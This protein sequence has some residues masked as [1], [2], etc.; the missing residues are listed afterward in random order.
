MRALVLLA[1][2]LAALPAHA[3][4]VSTF[5]GGIYT[6]LG[7][8][9]VGTMT[10][11]SVI[12]A[13]LTV[14]SVASTMHATSQQKRRARQ[15]AAHKLQQDIANLADRR[16]TLLQSDS[17]HAVVY[18][19]PARIG[20]AIVG[21]V[22]TGAGAQ[23]THIVMVFAAHPCEAIEEL[24]IDDDPVQVGPDGWTT[25][26]TFF[27][28]P[29]GFMDYDHGP[30]V[31]VSVHL[32]PG[33]VDVADQ[34]LIDQCNS[35]IGGAPGMWTA[36][37][38]LSGFTYAVVSVNKIMDRFQGGPP[39]V[40][41]KVR[42]KASILDVRTGERGYS[43]NPALCLADFI[44]S[45]QGYGATWDQIDTAALIAAANACDQEVYGG[46]ADDGSEGSAVNF[47]GS[48]ALYVCD[49]M[50][51]SDQDRDSTRQQLEE[52]MAG[53]SMQ[54]G[55]VWRIQ[56]GAWS[57]PVLV[58][59]D[60]DMLQPSVVVQTGNPGERVYNTARGT[61]VNA[62][63][64]GVS[65]DFAQYQNETFLAL[66]PHAK[67][68]D[69]ALPFTGAHVRCHQLARVAVER[70]RG[71]LVLQIF[72]KMLAWHLQPGDRVLLS[73]AFLGFEDKAFIV[74]DWRYSRTAPLTLEVQEDVPAYYDTADEVLADAAPNSN[75][76]NPYAPP[77]PPQNLRVESGPEQIVQQV[78]GAMV[79]ARVSWAPST[80]SYVIHGGRVRVQ[81]RAGA[82]DPGQVD[83]ADAS[84][85]N[86]VE[87]PGDAVETFLLGLDVGSVYSV[88]AR[89]ETTFTASAWVYAGHTLEGNT[90]NPAEV[91]GLAL[92][93]AEDG[94][95]ARW[96]A[97]AGLDQLEWDGTQVRRGDTWPAAA[98][99]VRFDGRALTASLGWFPAGAQSVWA[100][101]RSMTGRWSSPI[102]A[103]IAIL[104][105][106]AVVPQFELTM[107]FVQLRWADCRTTQPVSRYV[108]RKGDAWDTAEPVGQAVGT[109][110]S[111]QGQVGA[112][113]YWVVAVDVAGNVGTPGAVDVTVDQLIESAL[114]VLDKQLGDAF[115]LL[116]Q[117]LTDTN[118][119][120]A[121]AVA[122]EAQ[123]RAQAIIAAAQ[124]S[125]GDLA[126]EAQARA[127]AITAAV[128]AEAQRNSQAL[129]VEAQQRVQALQ[130]EAQARGQAIA[131]EAA[132]RAGDVGAAALAEAQARAS[133][134]AL[135]AQNRAAA[136]GAE[137]VARNA[138]IQQSATALQ[139][140]I[141][142]VHAQ[143]G[144]IL[145][146]SD[147]DPARAY[148][149]GEMAKA[150]GKLYRST[151]P[152]QGH[153]PPD[154]AYWQL[155]G[156]Y[157]SIG[158][159][160]A[161]L[162]AQTEEHAAR[163]AAVEGGY[164][165]QASQ[166]QAVQVQ[167][168]SVEQSSV[169]NA[170]AIAGLTARA[171]DI[172]GRQ[173][174]QAA[175]LVGLQALTRTDLGSLVRD[176]R[177]ERPG[178]WYLVNRVAAGA[179]GVPA[180]A[181]SAFVGHQVGRD[182]SEI[183]QE[184]RVKKGDVYWLSCEAASSV[185]TLR[186]TLGVHFWS[187]VTG[188]HI[189]WG[190]DSTMGTGG[191]WVQLRG[192][193]GPPPWAT[194][195]AVWI[196]ID[197]GGDLSGQGWYIT[198]ID[199]RNIASQSVTKAAIAVQATANQQLAT[200]VEQQ[201]GQLAAQSAAQ[202]DLAGKL[203]TAQG[204]IAAQGTAQQQLATRLTQT[205][206]G[207]QVTGEQV[208]GLT[209]QIAGKADA[210]A[211]QTVSQQLQQEGERITAQAGEL[212][213]VKARVGGVEDVNAGQAQSLASQGARI[214]QNEQ[215]LVAQGQR[216]DQQQ[217]AIG[218]KA[219]A[220]ALDATTARVA[221]VESGLSSTTA[222][223]Q[224]IEARQARV[225]NYRLMSVGNVA[226]HP[227]AAAGLYDES[228]SRFVD[229]GRSWNTFGLDG[230]G[231]VYGWMTWDLHIGAAD[232]LAEVLAANSYRT[233]TGFVTCDEPS[234][235]MS[236]ALRAQLL[237]YGATAAVI[238][239]LPYRGAYILLG[240][241]GAGQGGGI[242]IV[243]PYGGE[244]RAWVTYD[245]QVIN[246][247][248]AGLAGAPGA[249]LSAAA[250]AAA[251]SATAA[252]VNQHGQDIAVQASDLAGVKARLGGVEDV[253]AGQAQS[254][255]SQGARI[256]Q[257]EQGL[258]AQGQRLDQQQAAL[259]T[260][261]SASA[262]DAT[263]VSVQQLGDRISTEAARTSVLTARMDGL[264][265]G[266][267]NLLA[268]TRDW[269]GVIG[270]GAV[271]LD[272][273]HQGLRVLRSD[274]PWSYLAFPWSLEAGQTYTLS[275]WARSTAAQPVD[276]GVY[277]FTGQGEQ[278]WRLTGEWKRYSWTFSR[279]QAVDLHVRIESAEASP[280][281]PMWVAGLK[282]ERGNVATDWMPSAADLAQADARLVAES[283]ARADADS[284][285]S[286]QLVALQGQVAGKA[287]AG[288]VQQLAQMVQ[289]QGDSIAASTSDFSQLR[290]ELGGGGNLVR[291]PEFAQGVK[292]WTAQRVD[293][294]WGIWTAG[295][296]VPTGMRALV[297]NGDFDWSFVDS[298]PIPVSAGS[299]V[300]A[301]AWVAQ[302]R[303]IAARVELVY[304]DVARV[305]LAAYSSVS[306]IAEGGTDL[307][308]WQRLTAIEAA[309]AGTRYAV[310]R[311]VAQGR[312]GNT[313]HAWYVR[314]MVFL[315]SAG[316]T[317]APPWSGSSQGV[318]ESLAAQSLAQSDLQAQV[319][320]NADGIAATGARVDSLV[321]QIAG[322][323]DASA[324]STLGQ[325]V[326]QQG[327]TQLAQADEL[328]AMRA[329]LSGAE[330]VNDGQAQT[331]AGH[332][333]RIEQN[334]QGLV[335]QGQRLD[336][337]QAAIGTKAAASALDA[338][339]ARV[340]EVESGLSSAVTRTQQLEA[341]QA[342]V[343]NFRVVSVGTNS[344]PPSATGLY[345]EDGAQVSGGLRS[346]M[347]ASFNAL[348]D[349]EGTS[350]WD[351]FA[352]AAPQMVA[353]MAT[354]PVGRVWIFWTHDEPAGGLTEE[355]KQALV[356][357]GATRRALDAIP[358]RGA[359]VLLGQQGIGEGGGLEVLSAYGNAAGA[360]AQLQ[361]QLVNGLPVGLAGKQGAALAAAALAAA[362]S[363]TAATVNQ[364]GQ[365]IAA[366]ASQIA[367][368]QAALG[369]KASSAALD[370]TNVSVQQ[371]G[372]RV[373]T[374]AAR[375]TQLTS[376]MDG[377]AVGSANL[378]TGTRDWS[379]TSMRGG[380]TV[381]DGEWQ[382][383]KVLRCEGLW[384]Y[385]AFP[386]DFVQGE[387]YTLSFWGRSDDSA[388]VGVFW[389]NG[390]ASMSWQ[391]A[392]GWKRY[393]W[394]FSLAQS[395]G[396]HVRV[397]PWTA[398][399]VWI[400]GMKL[401]RGN[402][403]TDWM[404]SAA[405]LGQV[406]A[407]LLTESSTRA[408]ADE[409]Q[410]A[411]LQQLTARMTGSEQQ[412]AGQADALGG[413]TVRMSQAEG[414]ISSTAA[415]VVQ[416]GSS[417]NR[418]QTEDQASWVPDPR[419]TDPAVWGGW[420]QHKSTAGV[421]AGA[422]ADHVLLCPIR[423]IMVGKEA[424]VKEG[425]L[426][427]AAA[428]FARSVPL[429][430]NVGIGFRIRDRDGNIIAFHRVRSEDGRV[431]SWYL[432]DG[433]MWVPP[434]AAYA[435]MW[436]Q[437]D[438]FGDMTANSSYICLP[439][440]RNGVASK[441]TRGLADA[442][443][444]AV[445]SLTSEV[446]QIGSSVDAL[447]AQSV[448]LGTSLAGVQAENNTQAEAIAQVQARS[449]ANEQ[450][451]ASQSG[452]MDGFAASLGTFKRYTLHAWGNDTG[453]PR[454]L[455]LSTGAQ[456]G[457]GGRSYNALIFNGAGEIAQGPIFDVY[458]SPAEAARMRDWV[459]GLTV[460]TEVVVYT[461]DE[462]SNGRT[463]DLYQALLMLGG[464]RKAIDQIRVHGAYML[465]GRRGMAEGDAWEEVYTGPTYQGVSRISRVLEIANGY[466]VG[467]GGNSGAAFS[468]AANA[469]ATQSLSTTVQ[470]QGGQI[471]AGAA[472]QLQ[473]EARTD[474]LESSRATLTQQL[475]VTTGTA[476]KALARYTFR[477]DVDGHVSGML[478]DN[479]GET[480]RMAFL[481]DVFSI[482]APGYAD[483][484][485]FT[486][487]T[488]GGAGA[489]G[490]R[491]DMYLDGSITARSISVTQLSAITGNLG[492][493]YTGRLDVM[494]GLT[495]EGGENWGYARSYGKWYGDGQWGWLFARRGSDGHVMAEINGPNMG[496]QMHGPSGW[497]R[498]WGPGFNLDTGGLTINQVD[499]IDTLSVRGGAIN[500]SLAAVGADYVQ[501][502]FSV[503]A[504]QSWRVACHATNQHAGP[505][506]SLL[507]THSGNYAMAADSGSQNLLRMWDLGPG[508]YGVQIS[509]AD[510]WR[511]GYANGGSDWGPPPY[512]PNGQVVNLVLHICKK[513]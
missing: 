387:T 100:A 36:D 38:K 62:A 185:A 44:T 71:G 438:G 227:V 396:H 363:A 121:Q 301:A 269:T 435:Q 306:T 443:A 219:A 411:Q 110:F 332:G 397:E 392:P 202:T 311:L 217:A 6:W 444:A 485:V 446:A 54:S 249:V 302:H 169:A 268:G 138:A 404:P 296:W 327:A 499:V 19:S 497:M 17:P 141:D 57:T 275:F 474:G 281:H 278:I 149:V 114:E 322:K 498:L 96:G 383:L 386:F 235:G 400:A 422:P 255:A 371:L 118:R 50:F 477:M 450:G 132:A 258:V 224:Q 139:A 63:Q 228:G 218:T 107:Q 160:V 335:A 253:N 125:A 471:A 479:N 47:G 489:L 161:A 402:I 431:G 16:L 82:T 72:P 390:T 405:D 156:N 374:E 352:G 75:L 469:A 248:P 197:G 204:D 346:W 312:P 504:G 313:P 398:S 273:E 293:G 328:S 442:N 168:H 295:D 28:Q 128:A 58:L 445:G 410:A 284:A 220:S 225:R 155:V 347:A 30:M 451:L 512:S 97:P 15:E 122:A 215:G 351:V 267:A 432:L 279:A 482:A 61:Y 457:S 34:W 420:R 171:T 178:A 214:E 130:A 166:L 291:D 90:G 391:L 208:A 188:Q 488:V 148:A 260:K 344:A 222:R 176:G 314:P 472:A 381:I 11:G 83:G 211:L 167:L 223:T 305:Q 234:G 236:L 254:L 142:S 135:E 210:S 157:D 370:A 2:A 492:Q 209:G 360:W 413:L 385:G 406:D 458:G 490:F 91:Q 81:W 368:Q 29:G 247:W 89:F 8:A 257:T 288:V 27:K 136:L 98:A 473:L 484:P 51:R 99:D 321:G 343:R 105:P 382:G 238:D 421:P 86:D 369:T 239:S 429:G 316:Q 354:A 294:N 481:T 237:D 198:N 331:L 37:H 380:A 26:E 243:S 384:Q 433:E 459:T 483:K 33:G 303:C 320:Q 46:E 350:T 470:N 377:L 203:L 464:S 463:E 274:M 246:G 88:R 109:S 22:T 5:I 117:D 196:Q 18:G 74:T 286:A 140:S 108:V 509:A 187:E 403:A 394:T 151:A 134:I 319:N 365:D 478:F 85:W 423:D 340:A 393:S 508:S 9:A 310:V 104:P 337:Q 120:W 467:L 25:N 152:T 315:A 271:A 21:M 358:Y 150:G 399:P 241:K 3:E 53:F 84:A 277:W 280:A 416:L 461:G 232:A 144:D 510:L 13:A 200:T 92:W 189:W 437:L 159:A 375:T 448:N 297:F 52:S 264:A 162:A 486:V 362:Q 101:H 163:I 372:E 116:Q 456:V 452:R 428:Y 476:N 333:A 10:W 454:G 173:T 31:H 65:S 266:S 460:G 475:E 339:T 115:E 45:E 376:R 366:Q 133:A 265:V 245:L 487:G 201:G 190:A 496:L 324:V 35:A 379:G 207:L 244:A 502:N 466:I 412:A 43:R 213:G 356:G 112:A 317:K 177:F 276:A 357:F 436:I 143:L 409:A 129:A 64:N 24:Y 338:T 206:Q 513:A 501:V 441:Y 179:A 493:V 251:Q 164:E 229:P 506:F 440:A 183:G 505:V 345:R 414:Q 70:S 307:S 67:I 12:T 78:A 172:E 425:D 55:G 417:L 426:L 180:G 252:T 230:L 56:A 165:A 355:L 298:E 103:G 7:T 23:W 195:A 272:G 1:V 131:A 299:R 389:I 39:N 49:G 290:A 20:G 462:P 503:P 48:R 364:H 119:S 427:Y 79:R 66:D 434:G 240:Y 289:Q 40:T 14:V 113:R 182:G 418:I 184:W 226:A 68:L 153:A 262:L 480:A 342:R 447:A 494:A 304:L 193:V 285:Q 250:L 80:S 146:V 170:G 419:M 378:L 145:G 77:A 388:G 495:G 106:A 318:Q 408:A 60:A 282:V 175:D 415:D 126:A 465:V 59:G 192:E 341:R 449:L 127:A 69:M 174:S 361:F 292:F 367:Q 300:G 263:N 191:L 95:R 261:A 500:T 212:A 395:G 147:Y 507:R 111:L 93:V 491:G 76:P 330:S 453:N 325:T 123:N 158:E 256:E 348:G 154:A 32:S 283:T 73:S 323:A 4:P 455:Y 336:Q 511:G 231:N 401:E 102:S 233:F 205:E 137:V 309:P 181:P 407:K 287:E 194:H 329:R 124:Q 424:A 373:N 259:G 216:L 430:W 186:L 349:Y 308:N 87:L 94:I 221:E 242:E 42:G 468:A 270:N 199:A 41:A 439:D 359:Y 334:E 326:Q 353:Q